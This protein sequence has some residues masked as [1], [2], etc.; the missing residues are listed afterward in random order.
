MF[1]QEDANVKK[2]KKRVLLVDEA[3]DWL[4][5]WTAASSLELKGN[6][7]IKKKFVFL[8]NQLVLCLYILH[9]NLHIAY[10]YIHTIGGR[11]N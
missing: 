4:Q 7:S 8:A 3:S 5:I 6:K 2:K 11:S 10:T 1:E 9:A